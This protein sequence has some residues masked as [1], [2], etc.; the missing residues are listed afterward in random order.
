MN[1]NRL[2]LVLTKEE[3]EIIINSIGFYISDWET[4]KNKLIEEKELLLKLQKIEEEK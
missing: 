3:F 1:D 4:I 2:H